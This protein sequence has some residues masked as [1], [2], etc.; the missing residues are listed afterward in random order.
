MLKN[1]FNLTSPRYKRYAH[2]DQDV[3]LILGNGVDIKMLIN[4]EIV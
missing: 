4:E 3:V 1:L 2:I